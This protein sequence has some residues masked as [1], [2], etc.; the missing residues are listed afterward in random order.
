MS[1]GF[2]HMAGEAGLEEHDAAAPLFGAARLNPE[3]AS[4]LLAR[5]P[6]RLVVWVGEQGA[7]KT[8]LS[9]Q[10]YERQRVA[11]NLARFAGSWTLLAFEQLAHPTRVAG[12]APPAWSLRPELDLDARELLHL[13]LSAGEDP[14]HL[15]FAELPGELVLRL[16]DNQVPATEIPWLRRAD[17]LGLLIDGERLT[18]PAGRAMVLTRVRQLVERLRSSDLPHPD[19]GV[20]LV[21]TKWDR[22]RAQPEATAYWEA[23]EAELLEDVRSLDPD[24]RVLRVAAVGP[25][26]LYEVGLA[27]LRGWLLD[28]AV[29]AYAP[30]LALPAQALPPII[31]PM[32]LEAPAAPRPR[33]TPPLRSSRLDQPLDEPLLEVPTDGIGW[34]KEPPPRLRKPWRLR[35]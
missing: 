13:A 6:G 15:L 27:A 5:G 29:A 18:D 4:R 19:G 24:A 8:T 30:P 35:R 25:D 1:D 22:V 26:Q 3:E 17:K 21:V 31:A 20:A 34:L 33:E 10:L 14:L 12:G 7:G 11:G 2:V 16:A 23:R 32:P 9:V 28:A